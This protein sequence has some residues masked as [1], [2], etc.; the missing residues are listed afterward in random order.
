MT[1]QLS[2][3]VHTHLNHGVD[4]RVALV[5]TL[6]GV[7]PCLAALASYTGSRVGL[8]LLYLFLGS[9]AFVVN[10]KTT[11]EGKDFVFMLVIISISLSLL[12]S[13]ALV[14]GNLRGYDIHNEYYFSQVAQHGWNIES[15]GL[16]NSVLSVT[17]LPAF[18]SIFSG[19]NG[20]NIL[21]LIYPLI[22]STVPLL[23]YA[24]YRKI[25]SANAAFLGV[26]LFMA[27]PAFYGEMIMLARQE[28]AEFLILLLILFL[29]TCNIASGTA[30]VLV[31]ISLIFGAVLSHYSL[32]FIFLAILAVSFIISRAEHRAR[33][34]SSFGLLLIA[35]VV[36][37]LWYTSVAGGVAAGRLGQVIQL[38]VGNL[39]DLFNLSSRPS[40]IGYALTF[41]GSPGIFHAINR[42]TQYAVQL[43]LLLGFVLFARKKLKNTAEKEFLPFMASGMMLLAAA[44]ALPFFASLLDLNR[45]YHLALLFI[46][47]MLLLWRRWILQP[48]Q[49]VRDKPIQRKTSAPSFFWDLQGNFGCGHLAL[50]HVIRRWVG[51]GGNQ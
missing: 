15:S 6:L 38:V 19:L 31:T 48:V 42:I 46:A 5:I 30:D 26:F 37:V 44:V 18:I 36:T 20:L 40:T 7:V 34:L 11:D 25:V 2:D 10:I 32:A 14:S 4:R 43:C 45:T 12:L 47:A 51:L 35:L 24:I 33:S 9:T 39:N 28:I 13:S 22:Y 49:K 1:A 3:S 29:L 17:A 50:I 21:T 41:S 16:Y 8:L 23:L 27:Y